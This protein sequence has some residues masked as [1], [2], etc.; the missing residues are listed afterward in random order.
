MKDLFPE[1]EKKIQAGL[2]EALGDHNCLND[3]TLQ[4][5]IAFIEHAAQEI[6]KINGTGTDESIEKVLDETW[7]LA[8]GRGNWEK[9]KE[10][11]REAEQIRGALI[12]C[13]RHLSIAATILA[14]MEVDESPLAVQK[15]E[16]LAFETRAAVSCLAD[17]HE[18]D[19]LVIHKE[20]YHWQ[21]K[22]IGMDILRFDVQELRPRRRLSPLTQ[23]PE[24]M[25][26]D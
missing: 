1:L 24:T 3:D 4:I 23:S 11:I 16:R 18:L 22:H 20:Q 8:K 15:M 5:G 7:A 25:D 21:L 12:P 26:F 19:E 10:T 2:K 17:K 9:C 14:E 13:E 6:M